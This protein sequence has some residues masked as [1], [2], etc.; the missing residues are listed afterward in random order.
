MLAAAG[1]APW[2]GGFA[3]ID[4]ELLTLSFDGTVVF[5][6]GVAT[7]SAPELGGASVQIALSSDTH[8]PKHVARYFG[9]AVTT[10]R[11]LGVKTLWAARDRQRIAVPID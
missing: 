2:N 10:L 8:L 3:H 5:E 9:E 7:G 4:P 6:R 1:S 11:G